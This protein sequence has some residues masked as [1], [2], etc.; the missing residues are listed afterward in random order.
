[1]AEPV[2]LE[3]KKP[4]SKPTLTLYGTVRELTQRVGATGNNDGG[5]FP[6]FKTAF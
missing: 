6:K 4:Y 2:K 3:P 1:M 5:S